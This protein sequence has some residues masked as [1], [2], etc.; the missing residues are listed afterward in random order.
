MKKKNNEQQQKTLCRF[1]GHSFVF[2]LNFYFYILSPICSSS[3]AM[4]LSPFPSLPLPP[5]LFFSPTTGPRAAVLQMWLASRSRA[6][7]RG[8]WEHAQ[9]SAKTRQTPELVGYAHM[10][11]ALAR[12]APAK[13][14]GLNSKPRHLFFP[15]GCRWCR[16][17]GV[18]AASGTLQLLRAP[19]SVALGKVWTP[20]GAQGPR[21]ASRMSCKHVRGSSHGRSQGAR[22]AW[23]VNLSLCCGSP[24]TEGSTSC[25]PCSSGCIKWIEFC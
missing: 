2:F 3:L 20:W 18:L 24:P 16:S 8:W 11:V 25:S 5:Q 17:V 15:A 21:Y 13:E 23:T 9:E 6:L 10:R 22:P 1:E 7:P 4:C 19:F 14:A 12:P